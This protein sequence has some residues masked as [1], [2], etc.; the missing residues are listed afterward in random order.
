MT[1]TIFSLPP[2]K[3]RYK[4]AQSQV[5]RCNNHSVLAYHIMT[6]IEYD[7]LVNGDTRR[8]ST[9]KEIP[10]TH[11]RPTII[12]TDDKDQDPSLASLL[13]SRGVPQGDLRHLEDK[14]HHQ[15]KSFNGSKVVVTESR[16][17]RHTIRG[18]VVISRKLS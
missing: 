7:L 15:E 8:W 16:P 11:I 3:N 4:K 14:G 5:C 10:F 9:I 17:Y 1:I 2:G 12:L 13:H 6:A 18:V